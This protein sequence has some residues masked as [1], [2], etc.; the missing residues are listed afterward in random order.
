MA[1]TW[2]TD[3]TTMETLASA[4]EI[5]KFYFMASIIYFTHYIMHI[6]YHLTDGMH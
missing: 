3:G 2:L 6:M 4:W 1:Q 5:N